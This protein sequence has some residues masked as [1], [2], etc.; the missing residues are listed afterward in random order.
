MEERI[1]FKTEEDRIDFFKKLRTC[2]KATNWMHVA[3]YFDIKRSPF[4]SYQY[5]KYLLPKNIFEKMQSHLNEETTQAFKEKI[6]SNPKNWGA[7]KGGIITFKKHPELYETGRSI[8]I[9]NRRLIALEKPLLPIELSEDLCEFIGAIIGDGSV[10]GHLQKRN[11]LSAHHI[12]I[13]GHSILDKEYL[14]QQHPKLVKKLFNTQCKIYF[15]KD[16]NAMILNIHSKNIFC[17]LTERFEFKPGNKTHTTKI[18]KE[19][20]ESEDKFIFSTI[21]GIFDTDGCIFFD[22]R[23]QY[24]K[25]YP[26]IVLQIMSEPLYLQLKEILSKQFSIYAKKNN[27]NTYCIEIY[28]LPQFEKWMKL[29][30]FSNKKHLDRIEQSTKKLQAGIAPATSASL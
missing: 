25:P 29:I 11:G 17:L 9:K 1:G 24:S 15:R 3:K 8:A 12:S 7:R 13:T 30:G 10:D 18:P 5:G 6:F 4:Q 26:R 20:I 2:L 22:K 16:C 19:I 27:R 14:S 28:G 23:K 21:R